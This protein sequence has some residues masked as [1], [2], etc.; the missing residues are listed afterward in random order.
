MPAAYLIDRRGVIRHEHLGFRA[1]DARRIRA[2]VGELVAVDGEA[3]AR[4]LHAA[5][6]P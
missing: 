1:G 2:L 5:G 3:K 4:T 6:A